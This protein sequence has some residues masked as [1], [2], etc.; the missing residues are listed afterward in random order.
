MRLYTKIMTKKMMHIFLYPLMCI[1]AINIHICIPVC[2]YIY[3]NEGFNIQ[4]IHNLSHLKE[5]ETQNKCQHFLS[6]PENR[7]CSITTPSES[8]VGGGCLKEKLAIEIYLSG[9]DAAGAINFEF[10]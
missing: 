6:P 2:M 3:M 10:D 5:K 1:I 9:A 7:G 4:S 8:E